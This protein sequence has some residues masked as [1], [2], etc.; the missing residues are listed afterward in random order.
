MRTSVLN[1][2]PMFHTK[3]FVKRGRK[4]NFK[5]SPVGLQLR[6]TPAVTKSIEY[7][8]PVLESVASREL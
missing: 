5:K 3:V 4:R 2:I 6:E 8:V 7:I 1:Q